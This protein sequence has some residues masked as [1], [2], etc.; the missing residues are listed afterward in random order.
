M[1]IKQ[2]TNNNNKKLFLPAWALNTFWHSS[3]AAL[4]KDI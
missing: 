1:E 2:E 3:D 4:P